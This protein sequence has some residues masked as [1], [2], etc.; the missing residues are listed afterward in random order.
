MEKQDEPGPKKPPPHHRGWQHLRVGLEMRGASVR[1]NSIWLVDQP[2]LQAARLVGPI[3]TRVDTGTTPVLLEAFADPRVT[4]STYR[5]KVGHHY[6]RSDSGLV[7]VSVPFTDIRD[8]T[9]IRIRVIDASTARDTVGDPAFVA[10]LFDRPP[11]SMQVVGDVT[12]ASLRQHPDWLTVAPALGL[13]AVAGCIEIYIDPEKRYRWRIRRVSGEVVAEG[14]RSHGTRDACE[15][16]VA[17]VRAHVASLEVIAS[18]ATGG[19]CGP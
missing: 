19:A 1:V 13:A 6:G 3:F 17:W 7:Y 16:D 5:E 4:R 15:A 2:A 11:E 9:D 18:D 12:A 10:A 14:A 8:L